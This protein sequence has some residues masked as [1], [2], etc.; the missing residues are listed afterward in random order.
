LTQLFRVA[1]AKLRKEVYDRYNL[2]CLEEAVTINSKLKSHIEAD[3]GE[4][5]IERTTE[6]LEKGSQGNIQGGSGGDA[7]S[8]TAFRK[9]WGDCPFC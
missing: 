1:S 8:V 5:K 2:L 7:E 9:E 6:G 3:L 4:N